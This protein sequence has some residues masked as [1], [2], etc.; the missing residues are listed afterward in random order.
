MNGSRNTS[1][2]TKYYYVVCLGPLLP[3]R[4]SR[5][6]GNW[7]RA[8]RWRSLASSLLLQA[9][10]RQT[11]RLHVISRFFQSRM[12]IRQLQLEHEHCVICRMAKRT[13]WHHGRSSF[14]LSLHRAC[15]PKARATMSAAVCRM[16]AIINPSPACRSN[17]TPHGHGH[18]AAEC[19]VGRN[20]YH[21]R[22]SLRPRTRL[23]PLSTVDGEAT[24]CR[25]FP[26]GL[27]GS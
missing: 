16:I 15:R 26:S 19:S 8:G 25:Y 1:R 20:S 22:T 13:F 18:L 21:Y 27:G 17:R 5:P 2:N 10:D 9:T 11:P 12:T 23:F 7:T 6:Q 4:L 24:R 3:P 14:C